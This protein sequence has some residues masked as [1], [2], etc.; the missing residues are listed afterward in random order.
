MRK[1]VKIKNLKLKIKKGQTVR[2][3]SGKDAGKTGKVIR[4]WP[5]KLLALVE[6]VN[7]Y[8]KHVKKRGK[9]QPGGMVTL[10]RPLATSK[11]Q[12]IKSKEK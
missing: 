2:V 5:K 10:D 4:V 3:L 11:L 12:V 7:Q 1:K 8:V 9:E 6:G